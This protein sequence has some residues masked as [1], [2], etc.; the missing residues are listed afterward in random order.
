MF[1]QMIPKETSAAGTNNDSVG[2]MRELRNVFGWV[3][4]LVKIMIQTPAYR[5]RLTAKKIYPT[6]LRNSEW[7]GTMI[8]ISH[9]CPYEFCSTCSRKIHTVVNDVG[10]APSRHGQGEIS[11]CRVLQSFVPYQ[12]LVGMRGFR[13]VPRETRPQTTLILS[14]SFKTF[15]FLESCSYLRILDHSIRVGPARS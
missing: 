1:T 2:C 10:D 5:T 12:M 14:V 11:P 13:A 3:M 4:N 15:K 6:T 7:K 8:N 9:H